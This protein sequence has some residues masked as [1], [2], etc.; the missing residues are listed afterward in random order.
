MNINTYIADEL[1]NRVIYLSKA[2]FDANVT[3]KELQKENIDL[4]FS[5][6]VMDETP[7]SSTESFEEK[8]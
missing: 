3:I 6:L 4:K 7:V 8:V 5:M 1:A 2:L